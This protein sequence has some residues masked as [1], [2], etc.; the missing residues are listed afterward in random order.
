MQLSRMEQADARMSCECPNHLASINL[1]LLEFE[2]YVAMC[3]VEKPEDAALHRRLELGAY[4][5]RGIVESL[6]KGVCTEEG[7]EWPTGE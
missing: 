1:A 2:A 4:R 3:E 6:L 7:I 5:A